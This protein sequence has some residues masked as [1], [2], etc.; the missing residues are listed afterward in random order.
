MCVVCVAV[1]DFGKDNN[2]QV[3]DEEAKVDWSKQEANV[4]RRN[5]SLLPCQICIINSIN[6]CLGRHG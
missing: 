5:E 1:H 6:G 2:K 3:E 4:Q